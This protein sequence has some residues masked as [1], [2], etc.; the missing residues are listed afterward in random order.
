MGLSKS[1]RLC[2]SLI[3]HKN[4]NKFLTKYIKHVLSNT[5]VYRLD[6]WIYEL[7]LK[8]L[9][10]ILDLLPD[11][12][13]LKTDSIKFDDQTI[14]SDEDDQIFSSVKAKNI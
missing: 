13:S 4:S 14:Y 1:T 3:D 2:I 12:E 7:D 10:R 6:I 8:Q 11:V 9:V 5:Q